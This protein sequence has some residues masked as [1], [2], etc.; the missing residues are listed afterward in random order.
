[1]AASES[2]D[3]R[4]VPSDEVRAAFP[5]VRATVDAARGKVLSVQMSRTDYM[6]LGR[7]YSTEGMPGYGGSL[8]RVVANSPLFF[9]LKMLLDDPGF[10][11]GVSAHEHFDLLSL[12][13]MED[14]ELDVLYVV[15]VPADMVWAALAFAVGHWGKQYGVGV[16]RY[17][18]Q[19]DEAEFV[20]FLGRFQYVEADERAILA[21]RRDAPAAVNTVYDA[22]L[23]SAALLA[24]VVKNQSQVET[25]VGKRQP[26]PSDLPDAPA[27]PVDNEP[28]PYVPEDEQKQPKPELRQISNEEVADE[29]CVFI[30]KRSERAPEAMR[31]NVAGFCQTVRRTLAEFEKNG[32]H[33]A[34]MDGYTQGKYLE[35]GAA[36]AVAM[37]YT[38]GSAERNPYLL[39]LVDAF[40]LVD[41]DPEPAQG[42]V[43]V[44]V[45]TGVLVGDGCIEKTEGVATP[46]DEVE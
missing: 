5:R 36:Q 21:A 22:I 35:S 33:V 30:T 38:L 32:L 40:L 12:P 11:V 3:S 43:T 7:M 37:A 27:G 25:D 28:P 44:N 42:L 39:R 18:S 24:V 34:E 13:T 10:R 8:M 9:L 46:W 15:N 16:L 31:Q 19:M 6:Q 26:D 45:P 20:Q 1:M 23:R 2:S 4:Y 29:L 17:A 41:A 14:P